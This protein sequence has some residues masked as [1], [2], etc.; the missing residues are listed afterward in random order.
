MYCVSMH[1][2]GRRKLAVR[3]VYYRKHEPENPRDINANT[4]YQNRECEE[5]KRCYLR[6]SDAFQNNLDEI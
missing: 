3:P 1:H 6:R 4:V 2:F 5:K